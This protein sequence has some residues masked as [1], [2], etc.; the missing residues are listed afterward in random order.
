MAR[1]LHWFCRCPICQH[2]ELETRPA[3]RTEIMRARLTQFFRNT[4][5]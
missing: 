2:T 1:R 3:N 5:F 4:R